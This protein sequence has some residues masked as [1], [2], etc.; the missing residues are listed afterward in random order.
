M[1]GYIRV[2]QRSRVV[3]WGQEVMSKYLTK[4]MEVITVPIV[5]VSGYFV[6]VSEGVRESLLRDGMRA[7]E[8]VR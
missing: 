1:K 4:H 7:C 8:V 3:K 5:E 6:C 2:G